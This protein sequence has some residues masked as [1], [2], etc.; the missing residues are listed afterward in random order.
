MRGGI[1]VLMLAL[2]FAP[3]AAPAGQGRATASYKPIT[4][5]RRH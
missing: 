3:A 1:A 4:A 2:V 5:G